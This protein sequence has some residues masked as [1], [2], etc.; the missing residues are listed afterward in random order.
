[1]NV[2][3]IS[4]H[5]DDEILGI[6]GTLLKHLADGDSVTV[7]LCYPCRVGGAVIAEA[8]RRMGLPYQQ[9]VEDIDKLV[10]SVQPDTVYMHSAADLHHEHQELIQRTLVACRPQSG[11]RNL[12]AF[13]TPS[14]TDWG[15]RPFV[16]QRFVDIT[17][18]IDQKLEAM[19][20][21][22]SELRDP[23]HPRSLD[24]LRVRAAYWGQRVGVAYAEPFEVIR[25][26]G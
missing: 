13:E 16:P 2:L 19:A 4:A 5:P 23:P 10:A 1:M 26:C 17:A 11:V 7:A 20:A 25:S 6:G 3:C 14:A 22:E 12:Y 24:A 9:Q 21:Y 15:R 18:T 8:Q